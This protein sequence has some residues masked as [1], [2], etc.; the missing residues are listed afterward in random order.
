MEREAGCGVVGGARPYPGG[1]WGEGGEI[2]LGGEGGVREGGRLRPSALLSLKSARIYL[3]LAALLFT[4]HFFYLVYSTT[5]LK[6]LEELHPEDISS[7]A[8]NVYDNI[9]GRGIEG[10]V[11]V[12]LD[13][14]IEVRTNS[15]GHVVI[16]SVEKGK[17]TIE[18][19]ATGY[20]TVR[21]EIIVRVG[22]PNVW[23]FYL[24][25]AE[26]QVSKEIPPSPTQKTYDLMVYSSPAAALLALVSFYLI[27]KRDYFFLAF[28]SSFLSM[29]GFGFLVGSLLS[30]L[31]AVSVALH[32]GEFKHLR[33]MMRALKERDA[34]VGVGG[35]SKALPP[36]EVNV[37]GGESPPQRLPSPRV[38]SK[39]GSSSG[40]DSGGFA[41]EGND[42]KNVGGTTAGGGGMRSG[43]RRE[44]EGGPRVV[45]TLPP[46]RGE[47]DRGSRTTG[48]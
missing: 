40:I 42:G 36:P 12:L 38:V 4:A 22:V 3:L 24:S 9:T 32:Y 7:V 41:A 1:F 13:E 16:E 8:I 15:F 20:A 23:D 30:G 43:G 5:Y 26:G 35:S 21:A 29:A 6:G 11:V 10:A 47:G 45:R 46:S 31:A 28:T 44:V 48:R 33:I 18:I 2:G 25:A 27:G 39:I 19:R 37:R 17:H 34:G 14:G